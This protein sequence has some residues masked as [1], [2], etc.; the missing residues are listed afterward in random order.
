M[1]LRTRPV[2]LVL[3]LSLMAGSPLLSASPFQNADAAVETTALAQF[4]A[5]IGRYMMLRQRLLEEKIPGPAANS[6][7]AQLNQASDAL[8]AAIQRARKGATVGALFVGPVGTVLKRRIDDV[9]RR[10]NLGPALSNI[11]DEDAKPV[12]PAVHL[13]FPAASQMATMPPSLLAAL[14]PLPK[15]LEYRIVGQYLVLRD[16]DAALIL[17]YIPAIVPR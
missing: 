14:P 17:D 8:A 11:D 5:A 16:V 6:T 13:R 10:D 15:A 7:A 4:E 3:A 1:E 2:S 12:T 9:V